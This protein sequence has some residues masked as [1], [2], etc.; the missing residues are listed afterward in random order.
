MINRES[1]YELLRII[2]MFL[3]VLYHV[4]FHGNIL[5]HTTGTLQI[6]FEFVLLSTLI[7]VNVFILIMGYFQSKAK[8]KI[9]KVISIL[10]QVWF[11]NILVNGLLKCFNIVEYTNIEFL[12]AI[13]PFNLNS[14]W[15]VYCYLIMYMLSPFI[16]VIIEKADRITL[17]KVIILLICVFGIIPYATFGLAWGYNIYSIEQFILIYFIGA[18]IRKYDIDKKIMS[19]ISLYQKRLACIGIFISGLVLN[20]VLYLA[21][22]Y[23]LTIDSNTLQF[24]GNGIG[25]L[26]NSYS[27]PILILQSIAIFI[28]FGTFSFK[29]KIIN[30][31]SGLTLGVYL[32]H[33]GWYARYSI[34]KLLKI[35]TG[36]MIYGRFQIIKVIVIAIFI[37]VVGLI[38]EFMRQMLSKLICKVKII[39]K[40][41]NRFVNIVEKIIEV[42]K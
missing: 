37:F 41:N 16:N 11:Y 10:L 6:L 1:N 18:Y 40:T 36:N 28:L 25:R 4:I 30:Y 12:N 3:I 32:I 21:K 19:N 35:D 9:K 17:K 38:V 22:M 34:Y 24:L 26:I 5:A 2:S 15:F 27:N 14:Y 20:F 33:D 7:H 29:S 8:F 23:M 31:I 42:K 39:E 13:S